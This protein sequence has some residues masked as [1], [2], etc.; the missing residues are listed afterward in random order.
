M[1]LPSGGNNPPIS[2]ADIKAEFSLGDSLSGYRG[3]RWYK[4]DNSRGYFSAGAITLSDFYGTRV[5]S[6]VVAGSQTVTSSQNVTIP[7]FNNLTV[8]AYSG[9]GGQGGTN[10]NCANGGTGGS[11]GDSSLADYVATSGGGPGGAPSGNNGTR[12]NASTA[13][14]ITDANQASVLARYGAVKAATVGK[15]GKGGTTGYNSRTVTICDRYQYY[16]NIG[17]VCV[18]AHNETYCDSAVGAGT[19]GADG[20]VVLSWT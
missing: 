7:M 15:G 11:G 10:G 8:T 14:S 17:A 19:D 2:L 5:N 12:I 9:Y 20:S 6:P 18:S 1:T 3:Q 4:D 16:P 13:I